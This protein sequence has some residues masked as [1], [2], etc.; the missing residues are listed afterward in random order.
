[1]HYAFT[2]E[3]SVVTILR[4]SDGRVMHRIALR[5]RG[6]VE[7]IDGDGD[8]RTLVAHGS[9]TIEQRLSLT[10]LDGER[11]RIAL[12]GPQTGEADRGRALRM[13]DHD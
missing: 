10:G 1:M 7:P 2:A 13:G 8:A 3:P 11:P 4:K 12:M 6:F 9:G 5:T